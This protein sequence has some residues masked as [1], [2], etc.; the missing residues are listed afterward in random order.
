MT[1]ELIQ[2]IFV[3][4]IG[5]VLTCLGINFFIKG[6]FCLLKK[7]RYVS[8][9]PNKWKMTRARIVSQNTYTEKVISKY[10]V[11]PY[12][13][14]N[15]TYIEYEVDGKT[16]KKSISSENK[17]EIRI[18]Y[19]IKNPNYFKTVKELQDVKYSYLYVHPVAIFV[20]FLFAAAAV[21]LGM[22]M[23]ITFT[24]QYIEYLL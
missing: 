7:K 12:I 15:E 5:L 16:Y 1:D 14:L 10:G 2:L 9:K 6:I 8:L 22:L 24:K 23:I 21:P 20:H 19:K 18:Y 3:V 17:K 4:C 11:P 13:T